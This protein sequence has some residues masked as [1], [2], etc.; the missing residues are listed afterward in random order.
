MRQKENR[1]ETKQ[2]VSSLLSKTPVGEPS[3]LWEGVTGN[4]LEITR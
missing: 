3:A 2:V 1:A 4:I